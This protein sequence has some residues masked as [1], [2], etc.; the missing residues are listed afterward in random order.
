[1]KMLQKISVRLM[2][3]VGLATI[4]FS[5][6]LYMVADRTIGR[7]MDRNLENQGRSKMADIHS[8]ETRISQA[9]LAQSS[10]FSEQSSVLAAYAV[11]H[12]GNLEAEKDLKLA[13][14]RSML[15]DFFTSVEK[16]Y[17]ASNEGKKVRIHFHLPPARSLLRVWNAK[18]D[19]SDDLK[20]FRETILSIS[21]THKPVVGVEVGRGGFV[22][23]GLAPIFSAKGE[24]M[25]SVESLASYD[26]L[27]QH[28]VSNENE[29]MAVYMNSSLLPIAKELQDTTKHP[30]LA[31][32]FVFVSSSDSQVTDSAVTAAALERGQNGLFQQY[33]GNYFVTLFPI[34]DF[35]G[36]QAGVIAFVYNVQDL[37][38]RIH[39]I[40]RGLL[41]LCLALLI[42]ILVP[43]F[44]SVRGVIVPINRTVVMLEEIAKGEGDLTKRMTVLKQ[45]E[46]GMLA[47]WFNHF[48]RRLERIVRDFSAKAHG[49]QFSSETLS[50]IAVKMSSTTDNASERASRVAD[51]TGMMSANM[52]S[53]AAASEE[54]STNVNTVAL[55]VDEMAVTVKEI[56]ENAENAR[57]VAKKASES[58][59]ITSEKVDKLG[60]DVEEIGKVT[61]VITEISEQTNLLALN[62]TIEAARAGEAGKG[63]TVVANE[64]KE[65]ARQTA[66]ATGEIKNK[67]EAIQV[68]TSDTV[69]EIQNISAVI[70]EVNEIVASIATAIEEQAV[71]TS[72]IA[73]NLGQASSGI[74]EVNRNVAEVSVVTD[75][76]SSDIHEVRQVADDMHAVGAELSCHARDLYSLSESLSEVVEKFHTQEPRFDIGR[77]KD[78]HM[79]WR[80]RLESLLRGEMHLNPKD[81][82]SAQNCDFGRWFFGE[83]K[84]LQGNVH[85]AT[86][87][88]LHEQVHQHARKIAELIKEGRK[89]QADALMEDFETT[90]KKFFVALDELYLS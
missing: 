13:E 36:K 21:Q 77:V 35:S 66:S 58:A 9:M 37:Y 83:G 34:A 61:E 10:L 38:A 45:D 63:F 62:A 29:Q 3:P 30:I 44:F 80:A 86:V 11:A 54:A 69:N 48:L 65:L 70:K 28:A 56:A 74:T 67:I 7:F 8:S 76:I 16:G 47:E 46:I 60:Y 50:E 14:A 85:Y 43:I 24:Y 6:L 57:H 87:G 5:L 19:K 71:S 81:I 23:R 18:Q 59:S 15:R 73:Q 4:I 20:G 64:I 41:L 12:Q 33:R 72:E 82:V 2:V 32:K 31:D 53:V 42:A 89:G 27:V 52:S 17:A 25:G 40:K 78:A 90:R 49:L 88:E 79:Q 84:S 26:E 68:S 55:T 1:M 22:I 39:A 51:G 75:D